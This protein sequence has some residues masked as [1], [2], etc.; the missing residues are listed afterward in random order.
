MIAKPQIGVCCD[1]VKTLKPD[2]A[3]LSEP[4]KGNIE[5]GGDLS[6]VSIRELGV[7]VASQVW[8][9]K[10]EDTAK[11][12]APLEENVETDCSLG[13]S[14]GEEPQLALLSK[15]VDTENKDLFVR[16]FNLETEESAEE[17]IMKELESALKMVTDLANE[18]LDSQENENEVI[19][20]EGGLH[21]KGNFGE[22]GKGKS[23]S[24]NYD[25]ESVA[26]DFLDLLAIEQSQFSPSFESEPDSPRE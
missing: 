4:D 2:L 21:I 24:L 10:E 18:G 6:E 9:G 1:D 23:P 19:N 25:T 14:H 26:S 5:N 12:D 16:A 8:E 13:M 11:T 17:S 3:L 20:H 15:E 22:L 7:E